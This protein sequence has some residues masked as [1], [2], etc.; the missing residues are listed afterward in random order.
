ML[1]NVLQA[2]TDDNLIGKRVFFSIPGFEPVS[3]MR[4][5]AARPVGQGSGDEDWRVLF[6]FER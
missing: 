3:K 1:K 6:A 5:Y 2:G 4:I